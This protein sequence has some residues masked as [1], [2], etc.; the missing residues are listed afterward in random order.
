MGRRLARKRQVV[1]QLWR[2][3]VMRNG[4]EGGSRGRSI[5]LGLVKVVSY[6]TPH[7]LGI[8]Q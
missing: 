5:D 8:R 2:E 1:E 7:A 3:L 6:C 4:R